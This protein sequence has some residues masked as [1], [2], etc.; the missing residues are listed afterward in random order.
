V[1]KHNVLV[2]I[3]Y[4]LFSSVSDEFTVRICRQLSEDGGNLFHQNNVSVTKKWFSP[5][6]N[7]PIE[8][9]VSY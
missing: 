9:D 4:Y 8:E 7:P 6:Q 2:R 1:N 5:E 3:S